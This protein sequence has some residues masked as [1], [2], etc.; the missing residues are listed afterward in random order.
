MKL[1][2]LCGK[3]KYLVTSLFFVNLI[4]MRYMFIEWYFVIML[5]LVHAIKKNIVLV[6]I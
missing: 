6:E 4:L 3:H 1:T 2:Q 5:P